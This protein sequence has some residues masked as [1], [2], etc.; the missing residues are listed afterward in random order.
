MKQHFGSVLER[1]IKII[2]H[3]TAGNNVLRDNEKKFCKDNSFNEGNFLQTIRLMANYDNI[4]SK[5]ISCEESKVMYLSHTI[6]DELINLL[7]NDLLKTI[8]AEIN[9]CQCFSIITDSTQDII[10]KLDQ[11]S[12]IIR[13]VQINYEIK[14]LDV[15]E[16]FVGFYILKSHGAV[17]YVNLTQEVLIKL[18][19][20]INKCR[21]RGMTELL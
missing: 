2:L 11:L 18:G 21:G 4:L 13:Y 12:I 19:L 6:T 5:L 15:K 16:S 10:T 20:D 8:C 9:A 1:I 17:D 14:T 7:S 3:L